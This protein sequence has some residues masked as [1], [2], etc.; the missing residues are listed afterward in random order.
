MEHSLR[1]KFD[2]FPAAINMTS[3]QKNHSNNVSGYEK[4]IE[5]ARCGGLDTKYS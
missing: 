3:I 1:H 4:G 2:I 5:A